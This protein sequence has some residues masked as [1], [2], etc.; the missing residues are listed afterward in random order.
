MLLRVHLLAFRHEC[1]TFADIHVLKD[2]GGDK[3]VGRKE[4]PVQRRGGEGRGEP[5]ESDKTV[6]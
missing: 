5:W 2:P 4:S 3:E 6:Q 1:H